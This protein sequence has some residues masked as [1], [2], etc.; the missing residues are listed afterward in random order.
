MKKFILMACLSFPAHIL[1]MDS[2]GLSKEIMAHG[3]K[4]EQLLEALDKSGLPGAEKGALK[5]IKVLIKD[6]GI[7][8]Q[9]P[10]KRYT[11]PLMLAIAQGNPKVLKF[12]LSTPGLDISIKDQDGWG[13]LH[14]AVTSN[15]ASLALLLEYSGDLT[16]ALDFNERSKGGVTP[17][18]YAVQQGNLA[19]VQLLCG[20]DKVNP[21]IPALDF[22]GTY[23]L[24]EALTGVNTDQLHMIRLLADKGADMNGQS[25]TSRR[26]P[27]ELAMIRQ[28]E[29]H[30]AFPMAP[31]RIIALLAL[32]AAPKKTIS[33]EDGP[34]I[35]VAVH[36]IET[37]LD[38]CSVTRS[39][40]RTVVVF[41]RLASN[42]LLD[43]CFRTAVM[44]T[45]P[46]EHLDL[47]HILAKIAH[48]NSRDRVYGMTA[49]MW[50][51]ACG[52]LELA[53]QI[54]YHPKVAIFGIDDFGDTALHYAARNGH[55]EVVVLL[56]ALNK[57][58]AAI[59]NR[60]GKTA[61]ELPKCASIKR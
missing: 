27:L 3:S 15:A 56:L 14:H 6:V 39:Q 35:Q 21:N 50:A 54:L 41:T 45:D 34:A 52:H 47:L 31:D 22:D 42:I 36:S 5:A 7:N 57:E 8:F 38:N 59:R 18:W 53:K 24:H 13:V 60:N 61:Y 29:E 51:A 48:P 20:K 32:G 11:T 49:L 25:L 16:P 10:T 43:A 23:P 2:P 4:V 33:R 19:A 37:I 28:Q 30:S 40:G 1:G 44:G 55:A 58:S 46:K 17:V 12:L 9:F 26:T